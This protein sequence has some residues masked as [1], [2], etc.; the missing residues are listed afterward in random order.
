MNDRGRWKHWVIESCIGRYW[1]G[2]DFV[3]GLDMAKGM[4]KADAERELDW[5]RKSATPGAQ[6]AKIAEVNAP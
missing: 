4:Q 6:Y 2:K 3:A 5:L 1:N